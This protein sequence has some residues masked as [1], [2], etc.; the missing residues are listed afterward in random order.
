VANGGPSPRN[1]SLARRISYVLAAVGFI[2]YW[3]AIWVL[4]SSATVADANGR[5]LPGE[6]A[7]VRAGIAVILAMVAHAV[8][9]GVAFRAPRG[10]RL[11][12]ALLNGISLGLQILLIAA[13]WKLGGDLAR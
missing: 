12:P 8:G 13:G 3:G 9:F 5:T 4:M 1:S 11:L 6:G 10:Q 7:Q 2:G